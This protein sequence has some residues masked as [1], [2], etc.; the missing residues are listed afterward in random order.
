MIE[1]AALRYLAVLCLSLFREAACFSCADGICD[2][3]DLEVLC[4]G[5]KDSSAIS[6]LKALPN[7]RNVTKI[8]L[9]D[10]HIESLPADAFSNFESLL[11]LILKNNSI[12]N[13]SEACFNVNTST[14]ISPLRHIDLRGKPGIIFLAMKKGLK[15]ICFLN[16]DCVASMYLRIF[17]MINMIHENLSNFHVVLQKVELRQM[18][19]L[20]KIK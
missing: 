8:D 17:A 11:K 4:A 14:R 9:S 7:A 15:K 2:C 13:V 20:F 19:I 16:Y 1:R 18:E 5:R 12:E 6:R 3:E 10:N